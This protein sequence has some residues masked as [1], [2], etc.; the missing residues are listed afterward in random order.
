MFESQIGL[1]IDPPTQVQTCSPATTKRTAKL[2][3]SN[4]TGMHLRLAARLANAVQEFVAKVE[5]QY[6]GRSANAKSIIGILTL[7]AA[8]GAR[9]TVTA[10]GCD[11][12]R[13][14][15]VIE[16]LFTCPPNSQQERL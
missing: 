14:I 5:M 3:V 2:F 1:E 10:E 13:A 16:E 9:V 8:Q 6:G 15:R 7:G 4:A 11:A 12:D